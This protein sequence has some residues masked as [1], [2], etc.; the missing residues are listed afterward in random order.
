MPKFK[1]KPCIIEAEQ[2]IEGQRLPFSDRGPYVCLDEKGCWY[3]TTVHGQRTPI[4]DGDWIIP[5]PR[6]E[7]AAYPVKPDIFA[8]KYEP[9]EEGATT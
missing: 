6:G 4:E 2:F 9:V 8:E 3:V 7:F 5:E 1:N